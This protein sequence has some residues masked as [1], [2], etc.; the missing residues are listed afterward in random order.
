MSINVR[1]AADVID[2]IVVGS[3]RYAGEAAAVLTS[4][5]PIS[6]PCPNVWQLEIVIGEGIGMR[7]VMIDLPPLISKNSPADTPIFLG[8]GQS[9]QALWYFED[10]LFLSDRLP[11]TEIERE[12][13]V[14]RI[15][16]AT[17]DEK[18]EIDKLRASVANLEAAV[19]YQ[20]LGPKRD[21]IPDDVKLVVWARDGGACVRCGA[22]R[23]LHFDHIIPLAKGGGNSAANI[24]ILCQ[25]CNLRKSDNIGL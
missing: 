13:I 8:E 25:P 12:E 5:K 17:Y 14:L 21:P 9:G 3:S 22:Q 20:R 11:R 24:Q 15:K 16:K 18:G 10:S 4:Q 2:N 19:E 7:R 1:K 23:E 6:D